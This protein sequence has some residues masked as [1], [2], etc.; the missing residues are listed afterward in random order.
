LLSLLFSFFPTR[1][2]SDLVTLVLKVF[3][4]LF[5]NFFSSNCFL[6]QFY[7]FFSWIDTK[8]VG[9]MDEHRYSPSPNGN[10][11]SIIS[12]RNDLY[13]VCKEKSNSLDRKSTRLNS[14]HVS[15]SYAVFCLLFF[16][17][18]LSSFPTRRSSDLL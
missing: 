15:I 13:N 11:C 2:S 6:D 9:F 14:S 12:Y 10:E 17:H 16:Y 4:V 7:L 5:Y 3:V 8:A 18:Y 1:R